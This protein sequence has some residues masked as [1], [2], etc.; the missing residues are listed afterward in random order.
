MR[1]TI[2]RDKNE[3]LSGFIDRFEMTSLTMENEHHFEEYK[4]KDGNLSHVIFD[5][6]EET[7]VV[8]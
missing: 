5:V 7:L 8:E 1:I 2:V 4:D 6:Y 3:S